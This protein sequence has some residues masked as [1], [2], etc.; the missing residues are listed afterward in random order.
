[1]TLD[2]EKSYV[3]ITP[4]KNEEKYI[5]KT[6]NSV[7]SQTI[8][9]KR[10][11]IV[12]D[13]STDRTDEIVIDYCEK[14]DFIVLLR[15]DARNTRN[16]GSK[17]LAFRAGVERLRQLEYDFIG[18]LD[19]DVSFGYHY[20]ESLL[21]KFHEDKKLG[22]GGGRVLEL[23]KGV[24]KAPFGSKRR[25][26]PGAIQ[27]FR[28]ECYEDIGGYIPLTLGGED[29]VAETMARMHEWNVESFSDLEVIHHRGKSFG[30][31]CD[32]LRYRY[33]G[34]LRDYLMGYNPTFFLLKALTRIVEKPYIIGTLFRLTGYCWALARGYK[35]EVPLECI[36][37]IR[38]EQLTRIKSALHLK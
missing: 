16:F 1:M 31:G 36:S 25:S 20:F 6:L 38:K 27:L 11:V 34:G 35:K 12:S 37:S 19:A 28:R 23:K 4:A 29:G 9:P 26:V 13:G 14:H 15:A 17:V 18:N 24:Y 32:I 21:K 22:V 7:I 8:L 10:W 3:L 30:V 33:R 5:K 2:D